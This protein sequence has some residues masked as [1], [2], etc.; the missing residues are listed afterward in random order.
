MERTTLL[1]AIL[2]VLTGTG[3][4]AT[5]DGAQ[6]H[7]RGIEANITAMEEAGLETQQVEDLQY[8]ARI[9][10]GRSDHDQ[11][12]ELAQQ[13]TEI[14]RQAFLALDSITAFNGTVQEATTDGIDTAAVRSSLREAMQDLDDGRFGEAVETIDAARSDLEA[15]RAERQLDR[16]YSDTTTAIER[17]RDE[18]LAGAVG[19][20]VV[21]GLGYV[22]ARRYRRRHR[23]L[24]LRARKTALEDLLKETQRRYYGDESIS[25]RV[26]EQ[27]SETY[28]EMLQETEDE[29]ELFDAD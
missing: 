2:L 9:A 6:R 25:K 23:E 11:V 12:V 14:Q 29:L 10:Y 17:Y 18:A 24:D 26:F 1:L 21:G 4:A 15:R 13:V 7:L 27:R 20:L 8:D 3:T 5:A 28:R 16:L 22:V 19:L